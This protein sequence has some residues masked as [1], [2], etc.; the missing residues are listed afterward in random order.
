MNMKK[1]QKLMKTFDT[2]L[3]LYERPEYR[4]TEQNKLPY[5][6]HSL[7]VEYE[8]NT[9]YFGDD[10]NNLLINN[11]MLN[12]LRGDLVKDIIIQSKKYTIE[13]SIELGQINI[14]LVK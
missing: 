7:E 6:V 1:A 10:E 13:L 3:N 11:S 12:E 9:L 2:N 5:I 8:D 14:E 4:I